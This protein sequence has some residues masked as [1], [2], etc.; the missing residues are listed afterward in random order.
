MLS[1]GRAA[2]LQPVRVFPPPAAPILLHIS[3]S[4]VFYIYEKNLDN[5]SIEVC[6]GFA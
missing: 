2:P 1:T 5:I 4:P 6:S 3:S